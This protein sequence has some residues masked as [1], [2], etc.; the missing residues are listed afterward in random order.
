VDAADQSS[1]GVLGGLGPVGWARVAMWSAVFAAAI[2]IPTRLVPNGWFRRMT[3]TRPQDY[4]FLAVA[5]VLG[6]LVVGLRRRTGG[7]HDRAAAAG[8]VGT[9]LA[10]GCPVCNQLVVALV[11]VAGAT[12]VFAPIQ[13]L[14]GIASIGLLGWALRATLRGLSRCAVPADGRIAG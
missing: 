10:V 12:S 3:P 14:I 11:G 13:P 9:F 7:A 2:S 5:S 4:V 1:I 6:G 8:G